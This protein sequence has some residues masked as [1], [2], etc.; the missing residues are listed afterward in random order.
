LNMVNIA[1]PFA[2]CSTDLG[3][4]P[5]SPLFPLSTKDLTKVWMRLQ[6]QKVEDVFFTDFGGF[7]TLLGQGLGQRTIELHCV[8]VQVLCS[9]C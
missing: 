1:N 4:T 6:G 3:I 2:F 7:G 8:Y 9:V 5:S